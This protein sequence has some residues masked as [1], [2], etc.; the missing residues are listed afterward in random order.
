MD[1]KAAVLREPKGAFAIESVTLR[2]PQPGEIRV[3]IVATGIC[4]TDLVSRDQDYPVPLPIVLGHEGAGVVDAVGAGVTKVQ[5]GDHVVLT[6]MTCGHCP[7]CL[8]SQPSSCEQV[9]PLNFG[10]VAPDGSCT[11]AKGDESVHASFF[12][13]SSF[14]QYALVSERNCIPVTKEVPLELLGPLGCGVQTG[15]G[16]VLNALDPKAGSE[17]VI[18][19]AGAVGLSAVMAAKIAACS[20]IIAVDLKA[21]R[22]AL[23]KELGATHTL[24]PTESDTAEAIRAI[25]GQQGIQYALDTSGNTGALKEAISLLRTGGTAGI[26]AAT[27]LGTEVG[28][29]VNHM[30]F[31]RTLRGICEGEANFDLFIP[32]MV[33]FY[34]QGRFPFDRLITFY[35]LDQIN[36]AVADSESGKTIK[37]VLRMPA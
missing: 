17:I 10:G 19:G 11:I 12:G 29:D 33:E 37:P 23:A 18:Y 25:V 14:A 16:A 1:M 26:I 35:E 28:L 4:H 3:R 34:Q 36:Q 31:N 8:I 7:P 9:F 21:N 22:L 5:P 24:N 32:Q 30:I 27:A 13:Q 6:L 15:A 20:T 2:E